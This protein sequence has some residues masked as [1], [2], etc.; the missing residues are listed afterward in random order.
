MA[1]CYKRGFDILSA[2]NAPMGYLHTLYYLQVLKARDDAFKKRMEAKKER[3]KN[4]R[5]GRRNKPNVTTERPIIK[6]INGRK[7]KVYPQEQNQ[8]HGPRYA[9]D[10]IDPED[11]ED[12]F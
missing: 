2:P 11:L 6:T 3:E 9:F 12:E 10:G 1:A 5:S 7:V 8:R 4:I